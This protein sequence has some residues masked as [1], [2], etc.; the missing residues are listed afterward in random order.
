[1]IETSLM[2][3]DYPEAPEDKNKCYKFKCLCEAEVT[4]Y[5]EDY[6]TAKEYCTLKNCD[7]YEIGEVEEVIDY[8]V[9]D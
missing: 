1:M 5:A 7:N 4:V 8:T 2:V 9:E 6:E 3:H